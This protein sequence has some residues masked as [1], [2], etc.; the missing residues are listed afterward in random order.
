MVCFCVSFVS[1][2]DSAPENITYRN[3]SST[4]IIVS[5]S[6]PSIPNGIIIYYTVYITWQ[7]GTVES[8]TDTPYLTHSISGIYIFFYPF[9][10]SVSRP[11]F[12]YIQH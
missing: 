6:P 10:F 2:P 5:Y 9:L 12:L 4:E 8:A 11:I 7:N 3:V 1:V